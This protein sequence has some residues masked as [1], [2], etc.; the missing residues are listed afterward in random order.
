MRPRLGPAEYVQLRA[1][2]GARVVGRGPWLV[3]CP[4]HNDAEP[5]LRVTRGRTQP[6]VIHCFAGCRTEDV[7]ACDGLTL[8][9][10]CSSDPETHP[11]NAVV[12]LEQCGYLH[13]RSSAV[14]PSSTHVKPSWV[15]FA[16]ATTHL[17]VGID[18]TGNRKAVEEE[19]FGGGE[20]MLKMPTRAG[21]NMRAVLEDLVDLANERLAGGRDCQPIAYGRIMG[22]QRLGIRDCDVAKALKALERHGV[23]E[24]VRRL[25]RPLLKRDGEGAWTWRLVVVPAIEPPHDNEW[26][27]LLPEVVA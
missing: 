9:D 11:V 4:A 15:R 24:R 7:L 25:P 27:E 17:T 8:A 3:T 10:I 16:T 22:A 23:I 26:V 2:N 18:P 1:D 19:R 12:Q 5:S 6:V 20:L 21:K 13:I 14:E